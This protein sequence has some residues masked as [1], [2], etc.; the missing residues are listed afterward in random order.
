MFGKEPELYYKGRSKKTS[1]PGRIF[2]ILFV[3][4][5]IGFLIYKLLR[6]MKKEDVTFYDTY[7][8]SEEPPKV[9]ITNENFYGG[10]ALEDPE[11]YD[12]F[13]DESIYIPKAYFKRA[14]K[15]GEN[16]EWEVE[17]LELEKCNIENFGT[18]YKEL[19]KSKPLNNLYC[20][21]KMDFLLEGHFSYDLYSFFFIQFFPCVNT[22]ER[23]N[24]KPLEIIDYYLKNTFVSFQWEDIELT[25][26]NYSFP[27]RPRS[28]DIYTTVGKKLYKEI[29]TFFQVVN[30]ETD[31]D[32]IGF[33]EFENIKSEVYLK[34]DEMVSMS[35]VIESD[36]FR[37]WFKN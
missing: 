26:K 37:I 24:C 29:H 11:T 14:E 8:Y 12:V 35:N 13:I 27:M 3:L 34:Y 23:Q 21:K 22:S 17:E 18:K 33:D 20:F 36:I 32:F 25:P 5:Y 28:V 4:V 19:F 15:K 31:M 16:F 10:F 1:W 30:I 2:T 6:M 7:T 9:K